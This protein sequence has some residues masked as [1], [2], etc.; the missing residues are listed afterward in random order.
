MPL[1]GIVFGG[2]SEFLKSSF[3]SS[4]IARFLLVAK[5]VLNHFHIGHIITSSLSDKED[6]Y[7]LGQVNN[8]ICFFQ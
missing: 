6:V 3:L 8:V 4:S 2:L 1:F 7:A 5:N